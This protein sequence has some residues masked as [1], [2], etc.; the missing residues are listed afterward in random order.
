VTEQPPRAYAEFG[1]TFLRTIL[2]KRR[3]LDSVDRILG[4]RIEIGPIGAGPGRVFAR[5]KAVGLFQPC[6]GEALSGPLLA[7]RVIV[8]IEVDF[9]LDLAVDLHHFH[10]SVQVPLVLTA[11]IEEPAVLHWDIT[12]PGVDE[13]EL[14]L[15]TAKRRSQVLQRVAGLEEELRRFILRVIE[16]ELAKPH[17]VKATRIDFPTIVDNAWPTLADQFLP[18]RDTD[19]TASAQEAVA[20]MDEEDDTPV[21]AG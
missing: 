10:A 5:A 18:Q 21:R 17:V 4:D 13:V 11:R 12:V 8:P 19:A 9:E 14:S 20:E 6:F 2:H 1:E 7:Y 15:E 3:V 16:K